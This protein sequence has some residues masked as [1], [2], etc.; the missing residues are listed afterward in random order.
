MVIAISPVMVSSS[1]ATIVV[2]GGAPLSEPLEHG[3]PLGFFVLW[4]L[5]SS[6]QRT[7][8]TSLLREAFVPGKENI[9][10]KK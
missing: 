2:S 10:L 5:N 1:E 8:W 9:K 4:A 3:A 6:L 7:R